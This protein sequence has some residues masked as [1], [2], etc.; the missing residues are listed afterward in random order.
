MRKNLKLFGN[1]FLRNFHPTV[2][3]AGMI[4]HLAAELNA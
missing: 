1:R 3:L 4:L 2:I